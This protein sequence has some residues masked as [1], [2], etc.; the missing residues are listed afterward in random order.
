MPSCLE[1][2]CSF[3]SVS[4]SCVNVFNLCVC[5]SLPFGFDGGMWDLFVLVPNHLLSTV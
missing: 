4:V 5:A 3:V 1:K 2:S